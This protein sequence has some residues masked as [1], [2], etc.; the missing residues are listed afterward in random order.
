MRCAAEASEKMRSRASSIF[1]ASA[2][3]MTFVGAAE[4]LS[5]SS[6]IQASFVCASL[7]FGA[8]LVFKS[9]GVF[10]PLCRTIPG[11]LSNADELRSGYVD[12]DEESAVLQV[13]SDRASCFSDA[14]ATNSTIASGVRCMAYL[15]LAQSLSVGC[16][17][18]SRVICNM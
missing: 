2:A 7:V 4:F 8:L 1:V 10:L 14:K 5:E 17:V 11:S 15:F 6:A 16:A 3:M 13:I 12:A 9:M 18:M